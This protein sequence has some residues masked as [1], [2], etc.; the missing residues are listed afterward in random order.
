MTEDF[1]Q[2]IISIDQKVR[3]WMKQ[4]GILSLRISLGIIFFWFGL[5][6]YFPDMSPAEDLA[7]QT[8][9]ILT[10]GLV[11]QN[12]AIKIL[13]TWECAIGLGMLM[14][15]YMRVVLLLLAL[16]MV[17]AMS[18]IFL[19]PEKVFVQ[20]PWVPT[21]EGQYIIKNLVLISAAIVLGS[22]VDKLPVSDE[23]SDAESVTSGQ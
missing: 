5:L 6:K 14:G 11:S 18:P 7:R 17:G 8:F 9:E 10:F 15:K 16:Q 12:L 23:K 20:I 19:F 1:M 22:K 2:R 21:L 3:S 4:F 13:A